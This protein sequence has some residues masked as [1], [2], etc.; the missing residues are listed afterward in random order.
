[1]G[2]LRILI[3]FLLLSP[4]PCFGE[5]FYICSS[6]AG[7]DD[8]S[9]W[10]NCWAYADVFGPT[11]HWSD[12]KIAGKI[13][14]GDTVFLDGGTTEIIYSDVYNVSGSIYASLYIRGNGSNGSPITIRPGSH[15]P[16]PTGHDG[17]VVIT[18]SGY[19]GWITKSYVTLNG[20]K[21]TTDNTVNFRITGN[22]NNGIYTGSSARGV[23]FTYLEIDNNGHATNEDGITAS[24][25]TGGDSTQKLEISYCNIYGNWQDQ[26]H[27]YVGNIA[28][29]DIALIHDNYVYNTPDDGMEMGGSGLTVYDNIVTGPIVTGKGAGHPDGIV[30]MN[31]GYAKVYNNIVFNQRDLNNVGKAGSGIYINPYAQ[32]IEGEAFCCLRIFNNLIYDTIGI[33]VD[34]YPNGIVC[35]WQNDGVHSFAQVSDIIIANNTIAGI[36]NNPIQFFPPA[37]GIT[38]G[39]I[40]NNIIHNGGQ[41]S[42]YTP[43]MLFNST[44]FTIGS[45]GGAVDVVIDYN[46]V[47]AGASGKNTMQKSGTYQSYADFKS[48]YGINNSI[49]D[50]T[51]N[52]N[53]SSSYQPQ[54]SSTNIIGS[55]RD[56]SAYFTNDLLGN[57]R[58]N[59][60]SWTIGAYE[61][62]SRWAPFF[63]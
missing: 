57:S 55:G 41:N 59:G 49:S 7:N 25:S 29:Y 52:P 6:S 18:G 11:A 42:G 26:I 27:I 60:P 28:S 15:S 21:S 13:G 12:S 38:G 36:P 45:W 10:A 56:L 48:A 50:E 23:V 20:R 1:M 33:Q 32:T 14:P 61:Y 58:P 54:A 47:S 37:N 19:G 31:G 62:I 46:I 2:I 4:V 3:I 16:Y 5:N 24:F 63:R 51:N 17:R 53:L 30:V 34:D 44:S 9:S 8:G 43:A 22:T 35:S 39:Y 40:I